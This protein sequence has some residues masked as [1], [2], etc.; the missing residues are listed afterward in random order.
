MLADSRAAGLRGGQTDREDKGE[1]RKVE[2]KRALWNTEE[3]KEQ[4]FPRN[5]KE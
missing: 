3:L 1:E 4:V 2:L 5:K